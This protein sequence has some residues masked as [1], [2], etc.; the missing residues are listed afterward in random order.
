MIVINLYFPVFDKIVAVT[1]AP[2]NPE[3]AKQTPKIE[4]SDYFF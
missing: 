1:N 4:L 3:T 2:I